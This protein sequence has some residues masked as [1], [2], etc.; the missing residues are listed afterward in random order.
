MPN[1]SWYESATTV[2]GSA[3]GTN[4][5]STHRLN[6]PVGV[7]ISIYDVLYIGDM[8]NNRTVAVPLDYI[9]P[10]FIIGSGP[11]QLYNPYKAFP[12]NSSL[13]IADVGNNR[14]Q[15]QLL[16][17][18]NLTI[19]LGPNGSYSV[20]YIY[21]DKDDNIYFTN[22]RDHN[23]ILFDANSSTISIVAG[24]DGRGTND[25]QLNTPYGLFVN[26]IGTIYV[27]DC[28]NHRIMKWYR[29][30]S[31]G[32]RVAGNG[33]SGAS[34]AQLSSPTDIIVDSN[35]YMYISESGN[36]R[37]TRWAPNSTFGVCIAACTGANG[38][39]PTQLKAP[40]S[41]AFDSQ[42]SLYVSD[43]RNN[44]VQKFSILT[45]QSK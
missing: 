23:V 32:I 11:N 3:N 24:I 41:L 44:R 36:A 5:A 10:T 14:I 7:A 1:T 37:I 19:V 39:T 33:T 15:K 40:H 34:L 31:R 18:S 17:G 4:G 29:G 2:A 43:Y 35:E 6:L 30:A 27:A 45:Y 20:H 26:Q 22:R 16:N 28:A 8:E 9:T 21:V 38:T 42:G 13:Y 12:T 25:T